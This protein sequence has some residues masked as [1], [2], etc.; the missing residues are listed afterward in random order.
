MR[1]YSIEAGK[2]SPFVYMDELKETI[3]ISGKS[4]LKEPHWFYCNLLKWLIAFNTG[5]TRTRTFNINLEKINES[6]FKWLILIFG[7]LKT[8]FP[9]SSFEIN[10]YLNDGNSRI[11]E[12]GQI[13]Q[14]QPGFR[15]NMLR[16]S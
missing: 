8:I 13:L 11:L 16:Y 7:K 10:W 1:T 2:D 6:T 5:T 3:N 4:T 14:N 12:Y 9:D 15:V